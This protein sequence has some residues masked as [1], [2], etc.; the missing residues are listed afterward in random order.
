MDKRIGG[1][2]KGLLR[3][4]VALMVV[5]IANLAAAKDPL[6]KEERDW[7]TRHGVVQVGAFTDYPPF[8]F[9]DDKGR[10]QGMAIGFWELMASKLGFK[11]SLVLDGVRGVELK[12][13]DC[14]RAI[15]EMTMGILD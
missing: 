4:L 1:G 7:V 10:A 9:V 14:Q 13:G 12:A 2:Q 3:L 5:C 15:E 8:G 6:T 11:V